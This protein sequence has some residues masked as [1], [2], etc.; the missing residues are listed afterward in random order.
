MIRQSLLA[1]SWS[2]SRANNWENLYKLISISY[3]DLG[4]DFLLLEHQLGPYL[5]QLQCKL[6]FCHVHLRHWNSSPKFLA[7]VLIRQN[8]QSNTVRILRQEEPSPGLKFQLY[9]ILPFK[10]SRALI[11]KLSMYSLWEKVFGNTWSWHICG[12]W[13]RECFASRSSLDKRSHSSFGVWIIMALIRILVNFWEQ[14]QRSGLL[15]TH[16]SYVC[17]L[18]RNCEWMAHRMWTG[19][20]NVLKI[21]GDVLQ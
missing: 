21:A 18:C 7:A 8:Q 4:V 12:D 11:I 17:N 1:T 14:R 5:V 15:A 6:E 2:F 16:D 19:M 3:I 9:W 13:V 10:T 20:V